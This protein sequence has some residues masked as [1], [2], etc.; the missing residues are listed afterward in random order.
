MICL[1]LQISIFGNR[2]EFV[3]RGLMIRHV[4]GAL[5]LI[6]RAAGLLRQMLHALDQSKDLLTYISLLVESAVYCPH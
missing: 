1:P 5:H 2:L 4:P 6:G 3:V